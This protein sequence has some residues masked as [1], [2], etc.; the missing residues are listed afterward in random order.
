MLLP[1]SLGKYE[2]NISGNIV[3]IKTKLRF[4]IGINGVL[5]S[6]KLGNLKWLLQQ[7]YEPE[8][9]QTWSFFEED[10]SCGPCLC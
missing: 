5:S 3:D 7:T 1:S 8:N 6:E 4:N 2:K 9:L 10:L